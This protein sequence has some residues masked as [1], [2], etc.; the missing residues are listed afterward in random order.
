MK[1]GEYLQMKY[2]F[3]K[4]KQMTMLKEISLK[5]KLNGKLLHMITNILNEKRR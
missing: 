3:Q 2:G 1:T 4:T 5:N